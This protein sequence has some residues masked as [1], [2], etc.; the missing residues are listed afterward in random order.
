VVRPVRNRAA[1]PAIDIPANGPV[2]AKVVT[3]TP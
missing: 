1:S 2:P 3:W